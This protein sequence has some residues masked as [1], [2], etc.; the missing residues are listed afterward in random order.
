MAREIHRD[1]EKT[2]PVD[3]FRDALK[4][5]KAQAV[6]ALFE[7]LFTLKYGRLP[8]YWEARL[9]EALV[10]GEISVNQMLTAIGLRQVHEV[11]AEV[12]D[13]LTTSEAVMV[14]SK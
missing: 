11:V 14:S 7:Y 5:R 8:S 2:M 10:H 1:R 13:A 4:Q 12:L 9:A 3:A 6:T